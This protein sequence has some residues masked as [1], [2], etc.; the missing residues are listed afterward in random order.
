MKGIFVVGV[1]VALG[2]FVVAANAQ[3]KLYGD[4]KATKHEAG[5]IDVTK[6]GK[7]T[8][9]ES[10]DGIRAQVWLVSR[11]QH[12]RLTSP[13]QSMPSG[14]TQETPEHRKDS[15]SPEPGQLQEKPQQEK[16]GQEGTDM[17]RAGAGRPEVAVVVIQDAAK[18]TLINDA[19]VE[20]TA[21]SPAGK[22]S[23]ARLTSAKGHYM[24]NLELA[25]KGAYRFTL[26]ITHQGKTTTMDFTTSVQLSLAD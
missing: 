20:L 23:T 17:K 25:E 3:E 22:S 5:S 7:P 16:I 24:Q 13:E 1:V 18:N 2:L 21:T 4:P 10:K 12:N 6:L 11:E 9:S 26:K 15:P 14:E 19:K 8:F